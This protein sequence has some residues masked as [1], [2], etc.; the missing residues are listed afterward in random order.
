HGS[1]FAVAP[2]RIVTNAHVV[3]QAQQA[4]QEGRTVSVGVVPSQGAQ[5]GR[6][7]VVAYDPARDLALLEVEGANL[8]AIPLYVGPLD[9]GSPVAALGYPGNVDLA[10]AR[11]ADDYITPLPP[12]RSV[13]IFSNVR[14]INGITTLLHTANIARGHS[15]GPLLDQCGR[16]LGVNTLITRNQDGDAPF[17][18]AVANRELTVF[19]RQARQPFQAIGTECVSMSDR[20]RQDRERAEAEARARADAAASDAAKARDTHERS[21]AGIQESRE[22]RL[23]IAILCFALALIAAGGGGIMY[24]K[25]RQRPAMIFGGAGAA[26]LLLAIAVFFSR[27]SYAAAEAKAGETK[28]APPAS[29]FAGRNLCRLVPERSRVTVST[30]NEVP[31]DWAVNGCVN[32]RTQYAQNGETWTRTLVPE[33]EQAVAV[34]EF[35]P[36]TGDYVVTRYLLDAQSLTRVRALRRD[37]DTKACTGDAEARTVLADQQREIA[38]IL[39][40][41]P[42]ERLVYACERQGAAA[43]AR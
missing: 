31:L 30:A 21:L 14:P 13:G 3:A 5:A 20:L 26:L 2:N 24:M 40:R 27:P 10:T 36:A 34:L 1:G 35:T 32:G 16:V 43:P 29:R 33:G 9:D 28:A 22:T 39:P 41:L 38:R 4:Q 11:S 42:N 25:D 18:F 15:G 7:R 37:V 17:A 19:L 23:A 6:A 8:P 12:T